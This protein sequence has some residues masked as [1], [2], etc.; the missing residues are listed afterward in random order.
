MKHAWSVSHADHLSTFHHILT[1]T[2][3][4]N[5]NHIFEVSLMPPRTGIRLRLEGSD[6]NIGKKIRLTN[7]YC[8]AFLEP[9]IM[10]VQPIRTLLYLSRKLNDNNN[11]ILCK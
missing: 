2:Y 7:D 5:T 10:L 9:V 6:F 1:C 11:K 4:Q 8:L 3:D